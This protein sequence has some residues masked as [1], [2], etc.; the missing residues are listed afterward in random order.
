MPS[1]DDGQGRSL[2][3]SC[4]AL[5]AILAG[6]SGQI[7][8]L[9]ALAQELK[10]CRRKVQARLK[11][12]EDLG[13]ICRRIVVHQNR[14]LAVDVL[15]RG[16]SLLEVMTPVM[17][18][19]MTGVMTPVD[20]R[21]SRQNPGVSLVHAG[22]R[23]GA[24]AHNPVHGKFS[25]ASMAS[26]DRN[27]S[28]GSSSASPEPRASPGGGGQLEAG[29]VGPLEG[30]GESELARVA[31]LREQ[32]SWRWPQHP[33]ADFY[34]ARVAGLPWT[35]A[36]WAAYLDTPHDTR[37]MD[38]P[39]AK[40]CNVDCAQRW[41][42]EQGERGEPRRAPRAPAAAPAPPA[43]APAAAP[44]PWPP[45]APGA[46]WVQT[47]AGVAWRWDGRGWRWAGVAPVKLAAE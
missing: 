39:L 29:R 46:S 8:D 36:S 9:D 20:G 41:L 27:F 17:T 44:G 47:R 13:A 11:I 10:F 16:W 21:F 38:R 25:M 33:R 45:P 35:P 23:G 12:L 18:P 40:I 26:M 30:L 7:C 24:P 37:G 2:S 4:F 3:P 32:A 6:N 31:F 42:A 15:P 14:A 28:H 19:V 1:N 34:L 22:A 43:A 5:L